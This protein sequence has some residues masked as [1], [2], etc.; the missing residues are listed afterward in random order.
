MIRLIKVN[1]SARKHLEKTV[2]AIVRF[3]DALVNL[4]HF[5]II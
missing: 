1:Y 2:V 5:H 4:D 3:S